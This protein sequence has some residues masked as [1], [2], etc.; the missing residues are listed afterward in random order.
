MSP[1]STTLARDSEPP[2]SRLATL[3]LWPWD[4]FDS[5]APMTLGWGAIRWAESLLVQPNGPRARKPFRFTRDQMRFVLWWYALDA[6]GQWL[7]NHAARRLA[8]G[9]GKSPFAAVLALIEF[10][11]PVR[12]DRKDS[13]LPGG[14]GGRPVDMPLV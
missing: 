9:S 4:P 5:A 1:G 7:F 12:L 2:T 3:P 6:E 13:R 10:C 8:K 14:C 11:A